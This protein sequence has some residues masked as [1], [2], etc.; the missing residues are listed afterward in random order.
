MSSY[1]SHGVTFG[2][3]CAPIPDP[4]L[5]NPEFDVEHDVINKEHQELMKA[6]NV[7]GHNIFDLS[8]IDDLYDKLKT[9]FAHE[10]E[11]M[12]NLFAEQQKLLTEYEAVSH[13]EANSVSTFTSFIESYDAD[14]CATLRE[15]EYAPS[16]ESKQHRSS[17]SPRVVK[18]SAR[19]SVN[20]PH[21]SNEANNS[22]HRT[23]DPIFDAEIIIWPGTLPRV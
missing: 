7:V 2:T 1:P 23:F 10:E 15:S 3:N 5:W 12:E 4:F 22:N 13:D 8:A 20:L 9:H 18:R 19:T 14:F 6:V 16:I 11:I 17:S 21:E